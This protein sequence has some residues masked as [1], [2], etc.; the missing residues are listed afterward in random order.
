MRECEGVMAPLSRGRVG[1]PGDAV[2]QLRLAGRIREAE[3]AVPHRLR[4]SSLGCS[5]PSGA[6]I[7]LAAS[8]VTP[9]QLACILNGRDVV[10][11]NMCEAIGASVPSTVPAE[12]DDLPAG[13]E[14][15]PELVP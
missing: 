15:V 5:L 2:H 12:L 6:H 10:E 13:L 8:E 11:L 4:R 9:I 14:M 1:L 3:P 7:E